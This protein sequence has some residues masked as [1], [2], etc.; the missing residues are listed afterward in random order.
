MQTL[1]RGCAA[2]P[3]R[4]GHPGRAPPPDRVA[5]QL[6][7]RL[8]ASPLV[9]RRPRRPHRLAERRLHPPGQSR[10][11]GREQD[12]RMVLGPHQL[13]DPADPTGQERD[14]GQQAL[15]HLQRRVVHERG[16]DR[17]PARLAQ[18]V[19][20]S[21][22]VQLRDRLPGKRPLA[23]TPPDV[24]Q[25]RLPL[26]RAVLTQERRAES[27]RGAGRQ[28]VQGVAEQGQPLAAL[29]PAEEDEFLDR[30]IAFRVRPHAA[31]ATRPRQGR[32]RQQVGQDAA[33]RRQAPALLREP[34]EHV[35]AG[36]DQDVGQGH[37]L[38][39]QVVDLQ[40]DHVVDQLVVALLVPQR[41]AVHTDAERRPL[42]GQA[43]VLR[44]QAVIAVAP[45]LVEMDHIEVIVLLQPLVSQVRSADIGI[46]ID[47]EIR[48]W[49][50]NDFQPF[51]GVT[52]HPVFDRLRLAVSPAS[53]QVGHVVAGPQQRL[54]QAHVQRRDVPVAHRTQ[55]AVACDAHPQRPRG[56]ATPTSRP[57]WIGAGP[58]RREPFGASAVGD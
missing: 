50:R 45:P 15:V 5:V 55:Q 38:P 46:I 42:E 10:R 34:L 20:R 33:G 27:P 4:A 53:V 8:A 31:C 48:L 39:L 54:G 1:T 7:P 51:L 9:E 11:P 52:R 29:E 3:G 37:A 18:V 40:V 26:D 30:T 28:P 57:L 43:L 47:G 22:V 16:Q 6:Q 44:Q 58:R 12:R 49:E 24:F 41:R 21:H 19:D 56:M 23:G 13:R 14:A 36:A 25:A 2:P 35:A 17:Q 32:G